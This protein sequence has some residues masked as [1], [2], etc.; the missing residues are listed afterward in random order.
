MSRI[1]IYFFLEHWKHLWCFFPGVIPKSESMH[2]LLQGQTNV[3]LPLSLILLKVSSGWK[4]VFFLAVCILA[5]CIIAVCILCVRDSY[6][7]NN[8]IQ[9]NV[10]CHNILIQEKRILQSQRLQWFLILIDLFWKVP[11]DDTCCE[12]PQ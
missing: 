3:I 2:L 5:V 10:Y 7:V 4:G 6:R 9:V 1:F 8:E 12:L 11:S